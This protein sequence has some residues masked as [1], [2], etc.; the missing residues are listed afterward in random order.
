MTES[1]RHHPSTDELAAFLDGTSANPRW[2][3]AHLHS[4][5]DCALTMVQ[6]R[7]IGLMERQGLIP[8]LTD[9]EYAVKRQKIEQLLK[10]GPHE[11][12]ARGRP[13]PP[14]GQKPSPKPGAGGWA[15]L[16]GALGAALGLG[17]L[18]GG[19]TP[20]LAGSDPSA[21]TDG[22][23]PADAAGQHSDHAEHSDPES[24]QLDVISGDHSASHAEEGHSPAEETA[25]DSHHSEAVPGDWVEQDDWVDQPDDHLLD[26]HHVDPDLDQDHSTDGG[27][28]DDGGWGHD[29]S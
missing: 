17:E 2:V 29:D 13:A 24:S 9:A 1:Q 26:D 20:A 19:P 25:A 3:E 14:A 4:C 5:A 10:Q 28:H 11:M 16:G 23:S 8:P 7:R 21:P 12:F 27:D 22:Q 18:V 6:V 15:A